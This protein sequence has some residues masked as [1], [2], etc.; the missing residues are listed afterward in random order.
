M[1]LLAFLLALTAGLPV[2]QAATRPSPD[3]LARAL[4][5]RYDRV[6]DFTADFVQT[7]QGGVLST[8]ATEQG[9]VLIKKPGKM[10]WN[11]T[12]PETHLFVSGRAHGLLV[13]SCRQ[14]GVRV[15]YPLRGRGHDTGAVSG[16]QG[17]PDS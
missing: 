14:P 3:A 12:S 8:T 4:Q 13:C 17:R 9:T 6:G 11:Y 10:R 15:R 2:S 7:Y 1:A 16:R 5:D